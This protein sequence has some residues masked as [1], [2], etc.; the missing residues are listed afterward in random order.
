MKTTVL[1]SA[2]A[3]GAYAWTYPIAS[4]MAATAT[5]LTIAILIRLPPFALAGSLALPRML[6]PSPRS[7]AIAWV[8]LVSRLS[9]RA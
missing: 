9:A 4:T 1:I 7:T 2:L 5:W 3:T 8:L 6:V